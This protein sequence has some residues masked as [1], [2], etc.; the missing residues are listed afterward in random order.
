MPNGKTSQ[1]FVIDELALR[2]CGAGGQ[3][4][5]DPRSR[6]ALTETRCIVIRNHSLC[7]WLVDKRLRIEMKSGNI[8]E[9]ENTH[10]LTAVVKSIIDSLRGSTRSIQESRRNHSLEVEYSGDSRGSRISACVCACKR[11]IN[12]VC[13][14]KLVNKTALTGRSSTGSIAVTKWLLCLVKWRVKRDVSCCID[15]SSCSDVEAVTV[16]RDS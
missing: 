3:Q 8:Y 9:S 2:S 15:S 13:F 5:C 11:G 4:L 14:G 6:S 16:G 12:Q 10:R 7:T 1:A